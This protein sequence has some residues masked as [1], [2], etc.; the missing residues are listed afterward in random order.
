MKSIILVTLAL[1]LFVVLIYLLSRIQMM[2]WF[3]EI[4]CQLKKIKS[5]ANTESRK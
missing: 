2:G 4:E 3:H 1:I 5:H